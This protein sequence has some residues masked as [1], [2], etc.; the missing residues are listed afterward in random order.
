MIVIVMGVSGVGK[1]TVG[2]EL[3][4]ELHWRFADADD[5]HSAANKEKM[6]SGTALTD[7][8]REPWLQ[9]LHDTIVGWSDTGES[10]VL[11]C[12]ALRE[13]YRKRLVV[14]P[15]VRLV[16]LHA[17]FNLIASRLSARHGHY[18]SPEL[19]QSQFDTLEAPED[20]VSVDVS[21]SIADIV[22]SIRIELGV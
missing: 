6:R 15:E 4:R 19:L 11:A 3:A 16:F 18:M 10:V 21:G 13:S 8:D 20:A 1:T 7:A 17:S 12:S 2:E 5:F 9:S 14:G 22:T